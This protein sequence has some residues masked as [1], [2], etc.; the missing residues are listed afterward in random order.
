MQIVAVDAD[1]E[2]V[3]F[4]CTENASVLL[5]FTSDGCVPCKRIKSAFGLLKKAT[6]API[7]HSVTL[8]TDPAIVVPICERYSI[9]QFP[10]LVLYLAGKEYTRWGGFFDDDDEKIRVSKLLNVLVDCEAKIDSE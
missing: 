3:E 7:V 8:P 1:I 4:E 2:S 9:S 5:L 6:L 10:T